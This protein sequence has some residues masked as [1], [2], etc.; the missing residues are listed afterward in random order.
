[1]G[2]P[3]VTIGLP[4][5]NGARFLEATLSALLAQDVGDFELVVSDN[6]STDETPAILARFAA[7]DPRL[8]VVRQPENLGAS[9][10][11]G[12]VLAEAR[13][14]YFLWAAHDDH[15][16]P[17]YVRRMLAALDANPGAVLA[18]S[19]VRF[20]DGEGKP[21][22][23]MAD[24]R[25]LHTL[26]LPRVERLRRLFAKLRGVA[27]YGVAR[28]EHFRQVGMEKPVIGQ[29]ILALV[30]LLLRGDVVCVDEP[31]FEYR[32][33][34]SKRPA[35]YHRQIGSDPSIARPYTRLFGEAMRLLFA[36]DWSADEKERALLA[37]VATLI[38]ENGA[39]RRLIGKELF[40]KLHRVSRRL[41]AGRLLWLAGAGLP[42]GTPVTRQLAR[43][44][45]LQLGFASP[46]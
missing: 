26:G 3:R 41:L 30:Q 37:C 15:F 23:E 21:I 17:S 31:L 36:G 33:E 8:R 29:D 2:A 39:W 38:L 1:L 7:R 44:R 22:E 12:V 25:N 11:F 19:Q 43:L 42:G 28:T 18:V 10:N 27:I 9:R 34:R 6:A 24:E 45:R 4:V 13:T 5:Y 32:I 16:L 35:D 46:S 40:G 14:P 20:V